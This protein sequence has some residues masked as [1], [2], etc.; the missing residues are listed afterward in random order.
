MKE[1]MKAAAKGNL[2]KLQ[3]LLQKQKSEKGG[4]DESNE[5]SGKTALHFAVEK[6]HFNVVKWLLEQGADI[7]VQDTSHQTALSLAALSL[8]IEMVT[9]LL[10]YHPKTL[11]FTS[12]TVA[13]T[14]IA[15]T[16]SEK[17]ISISSAKAKQLSRDNLIALGK[18]TKIIQLLRPIMTLEAQQYSMKHNFD[19]TKLTR[20]GQMVF[21]TQHDFIKNGSMD[22]AV[23]ITEYDLNNNKQ[24]L[25]KFN[26]KDVNNAPVKDIPTYTL[27]PLVFFMDHNDDATFE[28]IVRNFE[29]LKK[30]GYT[31]LCF[32]YDHDRNFAQTLKDFHQGLTGF[33]NDA[34]TASTRHERELSR[35]HADMLK[36]HMDFFGKVLKQPW[37]KY[38]GVDSAL[39]LSARTLNGFFSSLVQ[40]KLMDDV[41]ETSFAERIIHETNLCQGGTIS[42]LGG[43]HYG[44]Q[45]KLIEYGASS[46]LKY[47]FYYCSKKPILDSKEALRRSLRSVSFELGLI[48]IDI[49]KGVEQG[50]KIFRSSIDGKVL[51]L[52]QVAVNLP[53]TPA[54]PTMNANSATL[55]SIL[56]QE[57]EPTPPLLMHYKSH[58]A[59]GQ[60]SKDTTQ[61]E[62]KAKETTAKEVTAKGAKS[63][64][65]NGHEVNHQNNANHVTRNDSEEEFSK[66]VRNISEFS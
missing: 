51:N 39:G 24:T 30:L 35:L 55:N 34:S 44:V 23:N 62:S 37:L 64:E 16:F 49:L 14:P 1:F 66:F 10:T 25:R 6:G 43:A 22:A 29:Y 61:K 46:A 11:V 20:T 26:G 4:I 42:I 15:G 60:K 36:I 45:Q 65:T 13:L 33:E 27:P 31:R 5:I 58:T 9:L 8:N 50:D 7:N 63:N 32:E 53:Q 28:L 57:S 40:T 21:A 12:D 47:Q 52:S 59:V 17:Y 54:S 18:A 3:E 56:E 38:V 41:R 2:K 48:E 19:A